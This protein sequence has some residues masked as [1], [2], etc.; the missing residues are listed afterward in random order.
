MGMYDTILIKCPACGNPYPAQTKGGP[1]LMY[2]YELED[3]PEDALS[4]AN[5]HSPY[6]CFKL[7]DDGDLLPGCGAVFE[8]DLDKRRTILVNTSQ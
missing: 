2:E 1:C 6:T 8:V 7:S 4:D 3:C 5:R